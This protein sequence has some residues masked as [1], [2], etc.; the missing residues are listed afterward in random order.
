MLDVLIASLVATVRRQEAPAAPSGVE[1]RHIH[2][3]TEF[4]CGRVF[5]FSH[6]GTLFE[7][8]ERAAPETL[9][10]TPALAA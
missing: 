4:D 2:R 9:I 6:T 5:D 10:D 1:V 8:G 7:L 3:D